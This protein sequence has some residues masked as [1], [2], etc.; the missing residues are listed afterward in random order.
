MHNLERYRESPDT[1]VMMPLVRAP[2]SEVEVIT[3]GEVDPRILSRF[4]HDDWVA[5]P[6]HPGNTD[7]RVPYADATILSGELETRYMAS[8]SLFSFDRTA[9]AYSIKAGSD[10]PHL[11][12][13]QPGKALTRDVIDRALLRQR[14]INRLDRRLGKDPKL[15]ILPE[16][17]ILRHKASGHGVLIRDLSA[18]DHDEHLY[19]PALS[20]P[21]VGREIAAANGAEQGEFWAGAY[22]EQVGRAKARLLLRYGVLLETP[23][24]QNWLIE[25]DRSYRP[26]GRVVLRDIAD[27]TLYRPWVEALEPGELPPPGGSAW[28]QPEE[29]LQL[30]A[31]TTLMNFAGGESQGFSS[32]E[33]ARLRRSHDRGFYDQ[34]REELGSVARPLSSTREAERFFESDQGRAALRSYRQ[35]LERRQESRARS[36]QGRRDTVSLHP[37]FP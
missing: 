7:P 9:P 37:A 16:V 36:T 12:E 23:N 27:S 18:L 35:R 34:L 20:I 33:M 21:Y 29:R 31:D 19:V 22:A 13:Q 24:P 32:R 8:R 28:S 14:L 26:T 11:S 25:L 2:R 5:M 17:L 4:V 6:R 10:Y 15:L 3:L 1:V 30:H